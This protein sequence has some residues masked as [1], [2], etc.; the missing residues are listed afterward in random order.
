M[1]LDDEGEV[2]GLGEASTEPEVYFSSG[3]ERGRVPDRQDGEKSVEGSSHIS[4]NLK[5][6]AVSSD[7][8]LESS[9]KKLADSYHVTAS[10]DTSEVV[11]LLQPETTQSKSELALSKHKGSSTDKQQSKKVR[12]GPLEEDRQRKVG[13]KD[14]TGS[15]PPKNDSLE[16]NPTTSTLPLDT[17]SIAE[18]YCNVPSNSNKSSTIHNS[19]KCHTVVEQN[20]AVQQAHQVDDNENEDNLNVTQSSRHT[21]SETKIACEPWTKFLPSSR[22]TDVKEVVHVQIQKPCSRD[23]GYCS[24]QTSRQDSQQL[25]AED[26]L[27]SVSSRDQ[28]CVNRQKSADSALGYVPG[29]ESDFEEN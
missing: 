17:E 10:A 24:R 13:W 22:K 21:Q 19:N 1:V 23:E 15:E 4:A 27:H 14:T 20:E 5:E 28:T 8:K 2:H 6:E 12:S 25:A 9:Q 7:S 16:Q 29:S 3:E 11:P 18:R 26:S